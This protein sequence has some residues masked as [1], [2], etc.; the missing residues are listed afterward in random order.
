[1]ANSNW[2]PFEA[3]DNPLDEGFKPVPMS[4]RLRQ[5]RLNMYE[6]QDELVLELEAPGFRPEEFQ[7]SIEGGRLHVT[8][9]HEQESEHRDVERNYFC[10]EI[11]QQ[12]FERWVQLPYA[13]KEGAEAHY[14]DGLLQ[15]RLTEL[16]PHQAKQ[17]SVKRRAK[18]Q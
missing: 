9:N 4:P 2:D 17:I 14:E 8:A 7:I 15:I 1:M 10:H 12:S 11:S 18:A 13:V 16:A 5:P 6:H 3:M